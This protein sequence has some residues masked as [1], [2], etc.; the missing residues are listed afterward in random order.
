TFVADIT[1]DKFS[2]DISLPRQTSLTDWV[3]AQGQ[4]LLRHNIPANMR[5]A[6]DEQLVALG[7][8][9]G[10][11]IPLRVKGEIFGTWHINSQQINAYTRDDLAIA[12]SMGDQ[13]AI[14]I[15]NARLYEAEQT[16]YRRLQ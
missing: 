7:I 16:Q 8:Q 2:A 14:A 4:P 11:V 15:D 9:T 6:E 1:N 3:A 5:F 10:M 12:G 13:L